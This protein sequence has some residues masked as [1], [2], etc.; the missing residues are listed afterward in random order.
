MCDLR[1]TSLSAWATKVPPNTTSSTTL[2]SVDL[3][4]S[5][6][7]NSDDQLASVSIPFKSLSTELP[8]TLPLNVS[9]PSPHTPCIQSINL[10]PNDLGVNQPARII[11]KSYPQTTFGNKNRSFNK[12]W[13]DAHQWL[14]YSSIT[15][16]VYCYPCR[17]FLHQHHLK[18][19][20]FTL[21]GFN[22]W[23]SATERGKGLSKHATS[24]CHLQSM[25][26]WNERENRIKLNEEIATQLCNKQ[27]ERNRYYISTI[28]NV[29]QF[30]VMN[31]M[32]LRGDKETHGEFFDEKDF[33]CCG[34]FVYLLQYTIRTDTHLKSIISCI[35][36]N[37]KY[38]SPKVQNE[39]IDI[40]TIMVREKIA[41][42]IKAADADCY[43][44]K[45]DGTRDKNND[46][47]LCIVIRF[48]KE[49]KAMERLLA[50]VHLHQLDADYISN[51]IIEILKA[52][53]LD[54]QKIIS[55]CHD[56]ASVMSVSL[57][58]V[59]AIIQKKLGK[60]I[61][62]LHCFNHQLHLCIVH[63]LEVDVSVKQFF[64]ICDGLYKFARRYAISTIYD[65]EKLK[66]LLTMRWT[67]H[68]ATVK[69][70]I[71]SLQELID[72]LEFCA[73]SASLNAELVALAIGFRVKISDATFVVTAHIVD[74]ILS[75]LHPA[76][77]ML[78]S[79]STDL[80]KGVELISATKAQILA[81]R[82][83]EAFDKIWS[84]SSTAVDEDVTHP[85]KRCKP[86]SKYNDCVILESTGQ[87][88][89]STQFKQS[90][91]QSLKQL[92]YQL[93]D[94]TLQEMNRRFSEMSSSL[95]KGSDALM[96][97]SDHFLE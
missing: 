10:L 16:R 53:D 63:A 70:V 30:L 64:D 36:E 87:N 33:L 34:K 65:G 49:G 76:N 48:V 77:I 38:T 71:N 86:N 18:D 29:M 8:L 66:R 43:T 21:D 46:E 27:L 79:T 52:S 83:E 44:L 74:E 31:E 62:Y 97:C 96:P 2:L 37:A 75:L 6:S 54:P 88:S 23:K 58:G 11:L 35:P 81:L 1:Q 26:K 24:E 12:A 95:M 55:Q 89:R 3:S 14:E 41:N 47:S 90:K 59:Q 57:G 42:E 22:H 40:M 56:G 25:I 17:I 60:V 15:D 82:C 85:P 69:T 92:F 73:Q 9:Q 50:I 4:H 84:K 91:K 67:G 78:Q 61:P 80:S 39:I 20:T 68:L 7:T 45:C 51:T 72:L 94:A 13:F 93:I 19:K 28:F 5:S 32:P